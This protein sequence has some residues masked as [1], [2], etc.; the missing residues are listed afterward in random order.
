MEAADKFQK[1]THR[2]S[3]LWQTDFTYFKIIHLGWW[4]LSTVLDDYSRFIIAWRLCTTMAATD[5]QD[6][7]DD[8]LE[9]TALE[10]VQV[11]HRP[12]LLS[13]NDPCYVSGDLGF[14]PELCGKL[15]CSKPPHS[16]PSP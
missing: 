13:D 2:V 3:Q 14:L 15:C 4:Y 5:V 12:R 6:T 11:N 16:G 7:L 1:P 8:A 9:F 10:K